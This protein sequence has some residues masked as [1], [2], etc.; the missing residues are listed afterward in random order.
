MGQTVVVEGR[1]TRRMDGIELNPHYW[2]YGWS[3][4]R[5]AWESCAG[6]SR[7]LLVEW[8]M[9]E[10]LYWSRSCCGWWG[11]SIDWSSWDCS[12]ISVPQFNV[13]SCNTKCNIACASS[14]KLEGWF[15]RHV[16][17]A[18]SLPWFESSERSANSQSKCPSRGVLSFV[19]NNASCWTF[20]GTGRDPLRCTVCLKLL[21]SCGVS[22]VPTH[23]KYVGFSPFPFVWT[24]PCRAKVQTRSSHARSVG[25]GV[26][27]VARNAHRCVSF[28][29]VDNIS[30]NAVSHCRHTDHNHYA[31]TTVIAYVQLNRLSS[32]C[33][34]LH[35][36]T[37]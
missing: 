9:V 26:F 19:W 6:Q 32:N 12:P 14:K 4:V 33:E 34:V 21:A 22:I 29:S 30:N 7:V 35:E 10:V 18:G 25:G 1:P 20:V 31:R 11:I 36:L 2:W 8:H 28:N 37:R 3:I 5:R 15:R 16:T 24:I 23:R 17:I 27:Y 13:H